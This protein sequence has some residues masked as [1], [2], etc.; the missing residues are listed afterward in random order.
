MKSNKNLKIILLLTVSYKFF[1]VYET[2]FIKYQVA[3]E[4]SGQIWM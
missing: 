2:M 4:N 1:S 3:V